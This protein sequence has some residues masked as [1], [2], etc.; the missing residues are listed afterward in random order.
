MYICINEKDLQEQQEDGT[1][2]IEIDLEVEMEEIERG[3]RR[4]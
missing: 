2:G 1:G 3:G 4:E